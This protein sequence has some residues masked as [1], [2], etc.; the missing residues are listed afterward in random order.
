METEKEGEGA[1]T[2]GTGKTLKLI[3]KGKRKCE[4]QSN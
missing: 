1:E 4:K 3:T 2:H